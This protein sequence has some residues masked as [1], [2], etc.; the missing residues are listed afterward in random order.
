[1]NISEI[2]QLDNLI[3][4]DISIEECIRSG[5]TIIDT[6]GKQFNVNEPFRIL[7][8]YPDYALLDMDIEEEQLENI[9]RF[10]Y[11]VVDTEYSFNE[12]IEIY[13]DHKD[14]MDSSFETNIHVN[15]EEP[16]FYDFLNLASD[17]SAYCGL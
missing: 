11:M 15:F 8:F 12:L 1:M 5:Y 7:E 16:T 6:G 2:E 4:T 10:E 17:C 14:G 9:D 3:G 13:K